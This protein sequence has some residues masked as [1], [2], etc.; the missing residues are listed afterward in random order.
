MVLRVAVIDRDACNPSK[1]QRECYRFCPPVKMGIPAVEFKDDEPYINEELCIGCGIC[2]KKCPFQAIQI[3]NLPQE[4]ETNLVH[5]YDINGFRLF[6][7]PVP[8]RDKILGIVGRN[9]TGKSTAIKILAGKLIPNFGDYTRDGNIDEVLEKFAGTQ[10]YYYFKDL[11][12]GRIRVAYKPQEVY[13]TPKV[14]SGKVKNILKSIDERGEYD[15]VVDA[16][17]LD[18]ALDKDVKELSGGE[19]QRLV[20]AAAA[21]K[22]ADVYLF[23]E[24]SSFND[25]F[26]RMR[27]ARYL[28]RLASKRYLIVVDHDLAFLDY[29]SDFVSVVYGSPGAYGIFTRP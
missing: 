29:I 28:R 5:Q 6:R 21:L 2:V 8:V 24:P 19:V 23:D 11:Y 7:L 18:E 3:V 22:D 16:L 14:V 15:V 12:N 26:Q 4:L 10:L 17:S 27:V 9:G 1:C 13:L 20:I 25:V